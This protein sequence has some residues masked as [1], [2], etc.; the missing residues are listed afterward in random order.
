[1]LDFHRQKLR[2]NRHCDESAKLNLKKFGKASSGD[3]SASSNYLELGNS[4][5]NVNN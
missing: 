5:K 2:S 3:D 1:M 4:R